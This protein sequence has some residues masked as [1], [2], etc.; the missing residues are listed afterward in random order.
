MVITGPFVLLYVPGKL[1]VPA[2]ATATVNNIATHETLFRVYIVVGLISETVFIITVA[3][4]Y[5]LFKDVNKTLATIMLAIILLDAPIAFMSMANQVAT[6]SFVTNADI[7]SVFD[8]PQRDALATFLISVDQHGVFVS[9]LFWGL[10]LLPLGVLINRSNFI[11]RVVGYWIILNGIA[12]VIMS[13]T[14]IM[15]PQYQGIVKTVMYPAIFGEVA[16]MLW[17][18]IV[19]V[20]PKPVIQTAAT[21]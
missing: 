4:L 18:L 16:L 5:R 19:G 15:L 21:M 10:W 8:K 12:Y 17:L 7:L 13:F 3:L 14:G 6:L 11:S 9:E 1:F 2:D 20:K